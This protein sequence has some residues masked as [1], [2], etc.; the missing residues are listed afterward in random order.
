MSQIIEIGI[1]LGLLFLSV[2]PSQRTQ[3]QKIDRRG[4]QDDL[5]ENFNSTVGDVKKKLNFTKTKILLLKHGHL[6]QKE[7]QFFDY[8]DPVAIESIFDNSIKSLKS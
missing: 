3:P 1:L 4:R 8:R 6:F 2:S 5:N 7:S